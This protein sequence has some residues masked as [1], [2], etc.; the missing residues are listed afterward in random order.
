MSNNL[1][2]NSDT[3][4]YPTKENEDL[5]ER[6]IKDGTK[7]LNILIKRHYFKELIS[8]FFETYK[9]QVIKSEIET[10]KVYNIIPKE[11]VEVLNLKENLVIIANL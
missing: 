11:S 8:K 7:I 3:D 6:N 4:I 1:V 9:K 10:I 2:Q 5:N